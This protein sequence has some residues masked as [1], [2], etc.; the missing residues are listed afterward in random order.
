MNKNT[1]GGYRPGS[2]RAKTGYYKGIYCGSTYE[3]AWVIYQIDNNKSFSRFDG[4]LLHPL[5][6]QKYFPDF[7]QDG[8]IIEI[9][10]YES[11]ES[12]EVKNDI[13]RLNGYNVV[14]KRKQDLVTEFLWLKEKYSLSKDY[15]T[16]Y[17]DYKPQYSYTCS[18]CSIIFTRDKPVKTPNK[19][20]SRKCGGAGHT[21]WH[22]GINQYTKYKTP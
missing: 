17:D 6:G 22:P 18:Y 9:K 12:V 16:L 5:T 1:H 20:C 2:G 15:Y 8:V 3:L 11:K 4:C 21:G 14:V 7:L 19:F 13:A 10:G